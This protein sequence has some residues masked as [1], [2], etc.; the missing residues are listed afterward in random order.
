MHSIVTYSSLWSHKVAQGRTARLVVPLTTETSVHDARATSSAKLCC[1]PAYAQLVATK[2]K[3][4]EHSCTE[5]SKT[6][7]EVTSSNL[8]AQG[9]RRLPHAK[10]WENC[11]ECGQRNVLSGIVHLCSAAIV[12][13]PLEVSFGF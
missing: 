10:P 7:S 9:T 13:K 8:V 11:R 6:L 3:S 1:I 5:S 2:F 12:R 4:A